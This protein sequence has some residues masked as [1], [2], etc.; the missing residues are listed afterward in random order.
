MVED[1]PKVT[2]FQDTSFRL[3]SGTDFAW[4]CP[5]LVNDFD[6]VFIDEAGQMS[7]ADA[8]IISQGARNVVLLGDPLQLAQVAGGSHPT[9][10]ELSILEHMLGAHKTVP[11]DH[12]VFL[13]TS[14]RMH[15]AICE[16]ISDG[17]YESRLG[18]DSRTANNW[19]DSPT[20]SGSGLVHMPIAHRSNSRWAAEEVDAIVTA[21]Q[22]LLADGTSTV[23]EQ[24]PRPLRSSD[25]LVVSPYNLQREKIGERLADIGLDDVRVG[26]VNKFQGL[27]A[28]I[29]FYSMATS[30][31]DDI[32]RDVGFLFET[33]RMNV[34]VSRAQ[35]LSILVYSPA[36]LRT[37]CSTPDQ[38][39][40]VNLLCAFVEKAKLW[41]SQ[42]AL[43]DA[44]AA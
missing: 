5:D 21:I 34:A 15:P 44:P 7:I 18:S 22:E 33:N 26:T 24:G 2:A 6:Y 28:P 39:V 23:R 10:C 42:Y 36:L 8:L 38:M 20:F 11:T 35:C 30:S 13:D 37:A 19:I 41:P 29:V 12:G 17:V 31:G 14:Y 43:A 4:A 25:I 3:F 40:L 1:A 9:G 32:P 16:F 27:E